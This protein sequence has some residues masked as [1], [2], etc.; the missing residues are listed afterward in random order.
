MFDKIR[1]RGY[2]I[3]VSSLT[4]METFGSIRKKFATSIKCRSG[5]EGERA[6]V[7]AHV[8]NAVKDAFGL[9]DEMVNQGIIEIIEPEDW[10]PDLFLLYTKVLEH[11]G[12][13]LHV[14]KGRPF[15]YRGVGSCDWLHFALARYLGAKAILTADAAFADIAGNDDEFGHIVIQMASGPLAGP[16]AAGAV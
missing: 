1:G 9:L 11:A 4:R 3:I 14:K 8:R 16:L 12:Y 5:S 2:R 15:R 6:G 7:D 10:S 13:V